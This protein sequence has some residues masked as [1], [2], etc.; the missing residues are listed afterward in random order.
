MRLYYIIILIGIS[1]SKPP[2]SIPETPTKVSSPAL[3]LPSPLSEG[4]I[5]QYDI[6]QFL[7]KQP[8]E[9]EVFDLLGLPDS[10]WIPDN[11]MYKILYYY[12]DK[13][14]DYNS[15]EIDV[16]NMKVNGFEWD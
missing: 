1:C 4:I 3:N 15:V 10:V 14:D 9:S 11:Q 13:L 16:N 7:K 5:N 8:H 6:W 12:V 2:V